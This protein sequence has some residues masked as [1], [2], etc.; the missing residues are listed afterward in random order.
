M[1]LF[2]S[3]DRVIRSLKAGMLFTVSVIPTMWQISLPTRMNLTLIASCLHLQ[4]IP[5]GSVSSLLV[6]A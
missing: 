5:L 6:G 1:P 3:F 2:S 4:R